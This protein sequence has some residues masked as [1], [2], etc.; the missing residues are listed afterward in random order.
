MSTLPNKR[1]FVPLAT[2]VVFSTDHFIVALADG[3]EIK[4]PLEWFPRLANATEQE[5][6]TFE[7]IGNGQGIHWPLLDEDIS[8]EGLLH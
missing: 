4:I 5:R 1:E 8:I 7:L 3:R 6:K 2:M